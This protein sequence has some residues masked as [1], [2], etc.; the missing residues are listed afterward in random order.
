MSMPTKRKAHQSDHCDPPTLKPGR[1][2]RVY[3]I[4]DAVKLVSLMSITAFK[5]DMVLRV[6]IL[7]RVELLTRLLL[8]IYTNYILLNFSQVI[9]NKLKL[10][11]AL[12]ACYIDD[13]FTIQTLHY[14]VQMARKH[15]SSLSSAKEENDDVQR[16]HEGK[17][18]ELSRPGDASTTISPLTDEASE[19]TIF[20]SL[21]QPL[22]P[23]QRAAVEAPPQLL[24]VENEAGAVQ[25]ERVILVT[26]RRSAKQ[27]SEARLEAKIQRAEYDCRYKLAFKAATDLL[28]RRRHENENDIICELFGSVKGLVVH[29]NEKYNLNGKRKLSVT[30]LY[31][32]IRLGKTGQSSPSKRG[33]TPKIPNILLDV[34]ASH[35][36]VSQVGNGGELRGRDIK[37]IMGAAVL[38]TLHENKFVLESAWKK[39]RTKYPERIQAGT[40]VTM[41][42][43]RSKWTTVNNLEQWFDD[44]KADLINSGLVID[45]EVRD[46][47]G[48]LLSEL[49]FRSDEVKRRIINMDETHH[50]L[51]I[52]GDKGGSRSLVYNNPSLQRGYKK[53]VKPGRHVTGVYATNASG[54]ALPPLYIF[55]SGAKIE[56]NY[57][58]K[59]SWLEGLPVVSGRFGCPDIVEVASFYSVRAKGS[60]DDSLFNDYIERVVLPL[61]PNI[62]KHARFDPNTGKLLCGPVILK[63]DSGPGRIIASLESVT[64]RAE[65]LENG[66]LILMGLPNATSVN[67]EMDALY[68]AFKSATYARG[69]II[70]THRLR[71]RGLQNVAAHRAQQDADAPDHHEDGVAGRVFPPPLAMNFE[72][73]A[74]IVDGN[75][76]DAIELKPFTR[77]FTRE[78]ILGSWAK[79]GFVPLTRA[80]VKNRKVRHELGQRERDE[81]LEELQVQYDRLVDMAE[82]HGLNAGVFDGRIPVA[83]HVERGVDEAD[84][85]RQLLAKKGSFSAS[86]LWN[87]C[88]TRIGNAS[89]VLRA[90]REQLALDGEKI[91]AQSQTKI[92]RRA[93][94]LQAAQRSLQKHE[95][96]P[97][98]MNDKDW[99]DIIKWVLPVERLA[100]NGF[101]RGKTHVT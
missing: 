67:Q 88:G 75:V 55:D 27:A 16:R 32:A 84:Q 25:P 50:D 72:D 58:I 64:K 81:S 99:I 85:V 77:N 62:S 87:V 26:R 34:V 63:V 91:A 86:A 59:L 7:I 10:H 23:Q 80:C 54:E 52:T 76:D 96:N 36:E 92:E 21:S 43:A 4:K 24:P 70:L 69:E 22:V 53:T 42:E 41:E 15:A 8:S 57:R 39:L 46:E 79:V 1:P 17:V 71:M 30:T 49:D 101:N 73:L 28:H 82:E 60:M 37:R 19:T 56:A 65:F 98:T 97:A 47:Q 94:Q 5:V 12:R 11:Q 89:V 93:K 40:K 48:G 100:K 45:R 35:S 38:G 29:L 44:A 95:T 61:Y 74:T 13:Q 3:G 6:L 33:P 20:T 83:T 78:K 2:Q 66:L 31:R 14:H 9:H 68:G 18:V 90:Q 51:S